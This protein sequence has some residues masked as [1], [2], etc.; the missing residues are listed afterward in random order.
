MGVS[1][2][3]LALRVP[4]LAWTKRKTCS[5]GFFRKDLVEIC[6]PMQSEWRVLRSVHKT[7]FQESLPSPGAGSPLIFSRYCWLKKELLVKSTK[8][9]LK[10]HFSGMTIS[11]FGSS[12]ILIPLNSETFLARHIMTHFCHYL[13]IYLFIYLFICLFIILWC[14]N[15]LKNPC[16]V[17]TVVSASVTNV[18]SKGGGITGH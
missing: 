18:L 2:S 17:V 12:G 15:Q 9:S 6:A 11:H 4:L 1:R 14:R 10:N 13:T 5:A 8:F 16:K 3:S 7:E